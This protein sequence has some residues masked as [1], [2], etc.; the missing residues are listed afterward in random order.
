MTDSYFI[1]VKN[2]KAQLRTLSGPVATFGMN[3]SSAVIQGNNIVVTQKDGTVQI[4]QF[5]QSGKGV[6]GPIRTIRP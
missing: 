1:I 5:S 4:Y 2:S 6:I 3:V